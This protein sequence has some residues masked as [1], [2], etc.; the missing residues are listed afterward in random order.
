MAKYY[1]HTQTIVIAIVCLLAVAGTAGYIYSQKDSASEQNVVVENVGNTADQIVSTSTDWQKQFFEASNSTTTRIGAADQAQTKDDQPLT[2][3][4]KVGRDFFAH[5]FEL[6]QNNL[7]GNQDLVQGVID[8]TI[9]TAQ[10]EGS[11]QKTYTA[12]DITVTAAND[13]VTL[14][15]YGN[16]VAAII[17]NYG[18]K[19]SPAD[20]AYA[21]FDKD[22]LTQLAQIDPITAA[23][24]KVTTL[25]LQTPV[26]AGL[27]AYHLDLINAMSSMV[28][29]SQSL[30]NIEGDP[31]QSIV[32]LSA[33][34]NTQ[35]RVMS[36]LL[37]MQSYF[38]GQNV[39][40]QG[41][42]AGALFNQLKAQ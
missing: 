25:L 28:S 11:N 38:A 29:V 21:A 16:T 1:P 22:D 36:S 32:S 2:L 20:I 37:S 3:T 40:F 13:A 42:E 23:Y 9:A 27:S 31:M 8:Q 24:G 12:K 5:Y 15:S 10:T 26:P 30:R 6:K 7:D 17:V 41:T 18:P 34:G 35:D 14:H 19:Q 4:D 33:Y 39:Q